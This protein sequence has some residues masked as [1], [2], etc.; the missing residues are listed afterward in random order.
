MKSGNG[1]GIL[2]LVGR[3]E[4]TLADRAKHGEKDDA[5][6]DRAKA[7]N[8]GAGDTAPSG[9][10]EARCAALEAENA[11]LTAQC[12]A[13]REAEARARAFAATA[14]DW[15]WE[16]DRD[17]RFVW[18]SD[19]FRTVTGLPPES[20]LGRRQ[21]DLAA[22]T[23]AAD[24]ESWHRHDADLAAHL[25]FRDFKCGHLDPEGR[26]H[27][28]KVSGIP[29]FTPE[30]EF[31]GYYGSGAD[32]TSTIQSAHRLA[33]LTRAVE[34]CPVSIV[35]TNLQGEIEYV[36]QK[37]VE[38]TGYGRDE[39][40]GQNPRILNSRCNPPGTFEG[41]WAAL[42]NGRQWE[43]ELINRRKDGALYWEYA[44]IQPISG[45]DGEVTNYLAIKSD[46]TA[47]KRNEAR[48]AALVEELRHS[49]EDLEQ[50]AYVA[51]HDLRQPLRMISAYLGLLDKRLTATLDEETRQFLGFALDGAKRLDRMIVDL[52]HYSRIGRVTSPMNPVALAEVIKDS[53]R[54]LEVAVAEAGAEVMVADDLPV[55]IGDRSELMR[56]FQNLIGNALT[57]VRPGVAPRIAVT[58][59]DGGSEWVVAVADNGVGIAAGDLG[60]VFGIFQRLV[61]REA[62]EGT[63]IGLAICRKIAEH[64]G[65][66]I[67]AESEPG[68]GSTFL[69]ALPKAMAAAGRD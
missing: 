37:F 34:Q 50:F 40:I 47:Q 43:G 11:R 52:L 10:V 25:P 13:L 48:L 31:L 23:V 8:L 46:I 57:Y 60:R 51:S 64:H 49:N 55:C 7:D 26:V 29:R 19:G 41:L 58:C 3:G 69:V 14:V 20:L 33:L 65:G 27:W 6:G 4:D 22:E 56:L 16:S 53:L 5:V 45:L 15:F 21:T 62:V 24:E 66:R 38:V 12:R 1:G 59:R 61:S 44:S 18:V 17:C 68:R 42:S 32:I 63:G 39:A 54:H 2:A 67:W 30:G 35:I 9:G 36:N 28:V